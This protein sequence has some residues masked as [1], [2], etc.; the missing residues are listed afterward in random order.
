MD[1][2]LEQFKAAIKK[3]WWSYIL[4]VGC[5]PYHVYVKEKVHRRLIKRVSQ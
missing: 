5:F 3:H 2:N 4:Q 1:P